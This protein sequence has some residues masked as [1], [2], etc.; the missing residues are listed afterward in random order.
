VPRLVI[1]HSG[2]Q[3]NVAM[4]SGTLVIMGEHGSDEQM[5]GAE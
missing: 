5:F 2:S 4:M 1:E 3:T